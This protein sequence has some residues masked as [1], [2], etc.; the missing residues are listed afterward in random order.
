MKTLLYSIGAVAILAIGYFAIADDEDAGKDMFAKPEVGQF[1][2]TVSVTGELRAKNSIEIY[3][4]Q[5]ARSVGVWQMK[6]SDIIPEGTV[7][8]QGDYVAQLDKSSIAELIKDMQTTV[9]KAESQYT[10]VRLDTALNLSQARDNLVN[11]Q[12]AME[13]AE[14]KEELSQFEAPSIKRQ[15]EINYEKAERA[16]NQAVASY[17]TKEQQERARMSEVAAEL[18]S[19]RQRMQMLL[20]VQGEF[21]V[22]APADGM[23]IYDKE[24]NGRKKVV[25]STIQAWSPVVATLPD[26][27]VM[28]SVTYVNEIDIQKIA[29]GQKVDLKLDADP[30]KSLAGEI[31]AVANIGEQRA[32]Y[33]SKV[34]EVTINVSGSDTTLRPAMT[35]SNEILVASKADVMSIPLECIHAQDS[36]SFVYVQNGSSPLRK[37]IEVGLINDNRAEVLS[38]ITQDDVLY[39]SVPKLPDNAEPIVLVESSKQT[40]EQQ[41]GSAE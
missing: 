19:Q 14:L 24:W 12:Y 40:E 28:E 9:Q 27:S 30:D 5:N 23:L 11:L 8:K 29:V 22:R 2:V 1:D 6:I 37:Q 20:A 16:Y 4:P 10:Q 25:G 21:T 41:L 38:G 34:F 39:L 7:V 35:T 36:I 31:T 18:T 32:N 33:D 17:N 3:G 15:A 13:E 26:L